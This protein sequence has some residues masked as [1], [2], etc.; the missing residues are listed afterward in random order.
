MRISEIPPRIVYRRR[1]LREIFGTT[2]YQIRILVADKILAEPVRENGRQ[3]YW[4][5]AQV[6]RA[7]R[8]IEERAKP[9]PII[10]DR[11]RRSKPLSGKIKEQIR[12]NNRV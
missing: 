7:V 8:R 5:R 4:T 9:K 6:E 12:S 11:Q 10:L 2:N 1:H 3:P